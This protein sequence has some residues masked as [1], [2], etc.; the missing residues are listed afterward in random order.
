MKVKYNDWWVNKSVIE[1]LDLKK[2]EY[3]DWSGYK[4]RT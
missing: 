1:K 3:R 4:S 2:V